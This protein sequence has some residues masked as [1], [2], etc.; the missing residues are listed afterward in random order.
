MLLVSF[1]FEGGVYT[2]SLAIYL[3]QQIWLGRSNLVYFCLVKTVNPDH[4]AGMM[5]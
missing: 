3:Q 5:K 1:R 4:I 2:Y